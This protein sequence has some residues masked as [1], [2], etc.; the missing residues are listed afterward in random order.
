MDTVKG[1]SKEERQKLKAQQDTM[2]H[3]E[4]LTWTVFYNNLVY[5][6]PIVFLGFYAFREFPTIMYVALPYRQ[7]TGITVGNRGGGVG[8][9]REAVMAKTD[10]W[11]AFASCSN[12]ALSNALT[13]ALLV[14]IIRKMK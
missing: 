2:T 6:A 12:F 4:A 10:V 3:F 8:G 13:D 1:R 14:Y 5:L 7:Y 11:V 9:T